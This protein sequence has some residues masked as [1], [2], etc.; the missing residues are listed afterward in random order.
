MEYSLYHSIR[1]FYLFTPPLC[2]TAVIITSVCLVP[3]VLA[4]HR[5][6][7]GYWRSGAL[8]PYCQS[9]DNST[10]QQLAWATTL[11]MPAGI[12]GTEGGLVPM[13]NML[14]LPTYCHPKSSSPLL[15]PPP[16]CLYSVF[17]QSCVWSCSLYISKL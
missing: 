6:P 15:P 3:G 7:P 1:I 9:E 14:A 11:T 4:W 12:G 8:Q 13:A 2:S 5:S 10:Q 16:P 17:E